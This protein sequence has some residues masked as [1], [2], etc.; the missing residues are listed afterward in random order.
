MKKVRIEV[1]NRIR[2]RVEDAS[3]EWVRCDKPAELLA[4]LVCTEGMRATVKEVEDALWPPSTAVSH[5][6]ANLGAQLTNLRRWLTGKCDIRVTDGQQI[7]ER[8]G[9]HVTLNSIYIDSDIGDLW[10]KLSLAAATSDGSEKQ[11]L[12]KEV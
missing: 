5:P 6:T 4:F 7:L 12:L 2:M 11:Q 3:W 1:F 9:R 10:Q 8:S